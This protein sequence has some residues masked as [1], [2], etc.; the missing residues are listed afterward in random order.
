LGLAQR[1]GFARLKHLANQVETWLTVYRIAKQIGLAK[2]LQALE[3][4]AKRFGG[5][6]LNLW[7]RLSQA[8]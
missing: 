1:F 6:G 8:Q 2:A 5:E 7:E 3:G 4:L